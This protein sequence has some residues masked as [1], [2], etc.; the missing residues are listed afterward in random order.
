[1]NLRSVDALFEWMKAN[2]Y[3]NP[4]LFDSIAEHVP[5]AQAAEVLSMTHEDEPDWGVVN[6]LTDD[7]IRLEVRS[8]AAVAKAAIADGAS[9]RLER[10]RMRLVGL[11]WIA[12]LEQV[13]TALL[14]S[15]DPAVFDAAVMAVEPQPAP[16]G[17]ATKKKAKKT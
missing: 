9:R 13:G 6:P 2:R 8:E 10:A 4:N 14:T 5:F 1:M 7:Q 3:A 16:R 15:G 11:L 12:G 17:H